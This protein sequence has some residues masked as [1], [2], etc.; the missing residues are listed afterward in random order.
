M[1]RLTIPL[2]P[3][4]TVLFPGGPLALR[5]FEP[6]YLELVSQSLRED[7]PFGICLIEEGEEVG[8]AAHTFDVGTLVRITYWN[9]RRDGLLGVTVR[10]ERRFRILSREIRPN[11][12]VVAEVE[13]LDDDPEVTV[14]QAY[15]PL[16][17]LLRSILEQLDHPYVNLP[18]RYE[19]AGWVSARLVELLPIEL[20]QKQRLLQ[21]DDPLK[22]L[23]RLKGMLDAGKLV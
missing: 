7:E 17:D 19:D 21:L 18:R 8:S 15:A 20:A 9:R 3:L 23:E 12:L 22:R 14:P 2:F 10:G 5:I 1:E 6:R 11:Q 13:L 4:H 16:K